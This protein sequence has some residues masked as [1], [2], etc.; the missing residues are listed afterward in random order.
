M[1]LAKF[2]HKNKDGSIQNRSLPIVNKSAVI[3]DVIRRNGI[4]TRPKAV[5]RL[6]AEQNCNVSVTLVCRVRRAM[7]THPD[8]RK[9][10]QEVATIQ[11]VANVFGLDLEYTQALLCA[12]SDGVTN[13]SRANLRQMGWLM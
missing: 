5:C 6:C 10:E 11:R 7:L 4:Q 12:V 9:L 1:T 13:V 2:L 3:Q 8:D